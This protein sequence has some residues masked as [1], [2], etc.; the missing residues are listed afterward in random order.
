[1]IDVG[2]VVYGLL[3][4]MMLSLAVFADARRRARKRLLDIADQSRRLSL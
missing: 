4:A 3:L 1:M 2:F